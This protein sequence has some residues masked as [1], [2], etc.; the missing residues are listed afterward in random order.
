M[1]EWMVTL[2]L[3][4][5]VMSYTSIIFLREMGD[6][7]FIHTEL[8]HYFLTYEHLKLMA[9]GTRLLDY[10][11]GE[12]E[13]VGNLRKLDFKLYG[14]EVDQEKYRKT[15]KKFPGI[16]FSNIKIGKRLPYEEDCFD[17]ITMFHVLEHV[18]SEKFVLNE[19]ARVL[20]KDGVLFLASPYKGIMTW[21]DTANFRYRF[22]LLHRLIG[23]LV[24][25][26][27]KYDRKFGTKGE[28]FGDMTMETKWHK[29]YSERDLKKLLKK[30]FEIRT[31]L[32]F[33][34]FH[35]FILVANNVWSYVFGRRSGL[36][37]KLVWYDSRIFSGNYAYNFLV[38][39]K[40]K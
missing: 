22:P 8:Y 38:I 4:D 33:S 21:A 34:M 28:L 3:L 32:K 9:V 5:S 20:K 35:Q 1:S 36:I 24:V 7:P 17:V 30:D 26:R 13:F 29:H 40:K 11:S 2:R 10:G 25:G 12:G 19:C 39:A 23:R 37:K 15:K 16:K 31:I 6:N 18:D 14:A 27:E